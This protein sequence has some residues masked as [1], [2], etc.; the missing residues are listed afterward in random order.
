MKKKISKQRNLKLEIAEELDWG[1]KINV[2]ELMAQDETVK[3][4][5]TGEN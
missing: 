5:K 4:K 3:M 1:P 2:E